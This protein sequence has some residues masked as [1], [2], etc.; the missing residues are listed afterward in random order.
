M[1][2]LIFSKHLGKLLSSNQQIV[3]QKF[4]ARNLLVHDSSELNQL[5]CRRLNRLDI[6]LVFTFLNSI[7]YSN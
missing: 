7:L 5:I 2:Q 6:E 3:W 1:C 4:D